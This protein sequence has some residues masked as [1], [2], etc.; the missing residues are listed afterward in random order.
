MVSGKVLLEVN[1]ILGQSE[2]QA[3]IGMAVLVKVQD[4][5]DNRA[6]IVEDTTCL[7]SLPQRYGSGCGMCLLLTGSGRVGIL[8]AERRV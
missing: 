1:D 4:L 5:F 3:D 7:Q 8:L 2:T 6:P